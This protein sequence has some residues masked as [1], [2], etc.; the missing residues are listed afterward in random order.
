MARSALNSLICLLLV[1]ST[2]ASRAEEAGEIEEHVSSEALVS[3]ALQ[4]LKSFTNLNVSSDKVASVVEADKELRTDLS[5]DLADRPK[6]RSKQALA[7][8]LERATAAVSQEEALKLESALR[9]KEYTPCGCFVRSWNGVPLANLEYVP[10]GEYQCKG[11][12]KYK[13]DHAEAMVVGA[14][15][16]TDPVLAFSRDYM[17]TAC[18]DVDQTVQQVQMFKST[19]APLI[20]GD[21]GVDVVKETQGEFSTSEECLAN[22]KGMCDQF[23][24]YAGID[25]AGMCLDEFYSS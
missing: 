13:F 16:V 10:G 12:A 23:D 22:C 17:G 3:H 11:Q 19:L 25:F 14:D 2:W 21:C 24:G 8:L 20:E 1:G 4:V 7:S 9:R 18:L 15:A 5:I 6:P